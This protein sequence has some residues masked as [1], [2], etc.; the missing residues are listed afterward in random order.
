L[1]QKAAVF[2]LPSELPSDLRGA[3]ALV[4][5]V[6]RATTTIVAA[7]EA[8][9]RGVVP[10]VSLEETLATAASGRFSPALT[11]GERDGVAIPGLD[12]GNS[13][14]EF[15]R[16]RCAGKTLLLTT[17]NGSGA[18][19]AAEERGADSVRTACLW[20]ASAA[21]EALLSSG[22]ESIAIVCAGT[23]GEFSFE[24]ALAAGEIVAALGRRAHVLLED[25]ARAALALRQ[26]A[27]AVGG[28]GVEA[29]LRASR[30]G[31]SLVAIGGEADIVACAAID[32]SPIVP[33]LDPSGM[34]VA[35]APG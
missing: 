26:S 12:H 14:L 3:A 32:R 7:L 11:A 9:C 6:L 30:G 27:G 21:A 29:A 2:F 10:I 19:R 17:T 18:I 31:R 33:I 28:G 13:P 35:S 20:N 1:A 4:I 5:D 34:L 8:S 16:D 23:R 25:S 22:V 15:S 24:D